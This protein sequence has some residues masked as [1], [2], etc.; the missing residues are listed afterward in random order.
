MELLPLANY[1]KKFKFGTL[2]LLFSEAKRVLPFKNF[3]F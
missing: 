2:L 3:K 1:G